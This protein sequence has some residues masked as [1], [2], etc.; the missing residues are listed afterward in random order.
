MLPIF[1]FIILLQDNAEITIGSQFLEGKVITLVK[2][3]LVTEDIRKDDNS[4]EYQIV[5]IARKKILFNTRPKNR[6]I[7]IQE[8]MV[9]Q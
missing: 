8:V 7:A 4:V 9:E 2:P 6:T 1:S 3:F 5:G